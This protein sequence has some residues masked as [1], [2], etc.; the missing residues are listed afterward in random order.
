MRQLGAFPSRPTRRT[1]AVTKGSGQQNAFFLFFFSDLFPRASAPSASTAGI[2]RPAPCV[3][4]GLFPSRPTCQ[5]GGLH[6]ISRKPQ[7]QKK[8]QDCPLPGPLFS[9]QRFHCE[10]SAIQPKSWIEGF[11]IMSRVRTAL[12]L[13]DNWEGKSVFTGQAETALRSPRTFEPGVPMEH[14]LRAHQ[15]LDAAPA[16]RPSRISRWARRWSRRFLRTTTM[17]PRCSATT[18]RGLLCRG[19]AMANGYCRMHGGA[20]NRS[21]TERILG[22]HG[23][24]TAKADTSR[25]SVSRAVAGIT[26]FLTSSPARQGGGQ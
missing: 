12:K 1:G 14:M 18:R 7:S 9:P 8:Y 24:L 26:R 2:T 10:T 16:P 15:E 17:V 25:Q 5:A 20:R 23:A 4:L 13:A 22:A 6:G 3:S 11:I 21:L 19:P